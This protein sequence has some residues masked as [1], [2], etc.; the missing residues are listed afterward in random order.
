MVPS[1]VVRDIAE[2][3]LAQFESREEGLVVLGQATGE[4]PDTWRKRLSE[5]TYVTRTG[6]R[7]PHGWYA[8]THVDEDSLDRLLTGIDRTDLWHSPELA[9]YQPQPEQSEED[10]AATCLDCGTWIDWTEKGA[11][12]IVEIG[13]V[14]NV[15]TSYR[16][17]PLCPVCTSNRFPL[18][19]PKPDAVGRKARKIPNSDVHRLYVEYV[20]AGIGMRQLCDREFERWGYKS[21]QSMMSSLFQQWE[22]AGWPMRGRSASKSKNRTNGH[23]KRKVAAKIPEQTLR[24]L[25]KLHYRY[26]VSLNQMGRELYEKLGYRRPQTCA[27]AIAAGWRALGLK[28]RDRIEMTVAKSTTNGLSPRNWKDRKKRRL[29]AGLTLKGKHRRIC[30]GTTKH[31]GR[32]GER[33]ARPA[34][35]GSAFCQSHAPEKQEAIR[36]RLIQARANSPVA[37]NTVPVGLILPDLLRYKEVYG[38]YRVLEELTGFSEAMLYRQAKRLPDERMMN[39]TYLRLRAAL[40]R[41]LS[42]ELIAAA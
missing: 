11:G 3:W 27:V 24:K 17:F 39:D 41:L 16:W 2:R 40:D 25:H 21:A 29:E 19:E 14:V 33:C 12:V 30:A 36:E 35:K 42:D 28:A 23:V 20:R 4:P 1:T 6:R 32:K 37:R 31:R 15:R 10:Y 38:R 5:N 26:D 7:S 34:L 18:A 8:K 13:Q 9:P 22:R